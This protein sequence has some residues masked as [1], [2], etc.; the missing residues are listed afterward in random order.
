MVPVRRAVEPSLIGRV[1]AENHDAD[2]VGLEVQ[3]H[4][5]DAAVE[6]DHLA[7]LDIIEA[8]DAGDA[9]ADGEDGADFR[10]FRIGL[11]VGDLVANDPGNFSGADIHCLCLAFHRVSEWVEF[12]ADRAVDHLAAQLDDQPAEDVGIDAG[13]ERDVA[14]GA[15]A[16]LRRKRRQLV[17][18]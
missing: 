12:G 1:R 9:V 7:G 11:E 3:R 16:Q 5:F 6:L 14:A 17:V 2:I 4:A 13:F 18:L 10:D 8:V 15:G